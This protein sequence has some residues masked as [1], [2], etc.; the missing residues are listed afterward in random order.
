M[1]KDG[2][3]LIWL[4]G[5]SR[6]YH[7]VLYEQFL[8]RELLDTEVVHHKNG[9]KLD[10]RIENLELMCR[11]EHSVMHGEELADKFRI[12]N[13]KGVNTVTHKQCS[14]CNVLKSRD[15]FYKCKRWKRTGY[16]TNSRCK[17]CDRVRNKLKARNK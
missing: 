2:Y 1:S 9:D 7:R 15:E 11:R 16:R 5:G 8:G 13:L 6:N 17:D 10:N 14:V 12:Q 4:D 3:L